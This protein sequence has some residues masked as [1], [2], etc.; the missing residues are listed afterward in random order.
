[1]RRAKI[2]EQNRFLLQRQREFRIAADVVADAWASHREVEAVAVIGSVA[3]PLWKEV[4]RFSEFRR[5]G[6]EVWHEC[7]DLDIAVWIDSLDR[8]DALRRAAALAL[9]AAFERGAGTSVVPQQLDIFLIEPGSDRYLGRLCSFNACPKDKQD[10]E[11]P[12]CGAIRFNKVVLGFQPRPDLLEPARYATLYKR[13]KGRVLSALDLPTVEGIGAM[14][15]SEKA[16]SVPR[17]SRD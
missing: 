15:G 1:M 3:K 10:C 9:R 7:G 11:A 6:I 8:L 13:G 12:G 4:P 14:I 17:R 5:A 16:R 2:D